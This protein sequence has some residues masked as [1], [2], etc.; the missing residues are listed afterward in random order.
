LGESEVDQLLRECAGQAGGAGLPML[1]ANPDEVT[2]AGDK[3]VKMPGAFAVLYHMEMNVEMDR[4]QYVD[5]NLPFFNH[6]HNDQHHSFL[7][8]KVKTN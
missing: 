6:N 5:Y 8:E 1:V 4:I 2:V 7:L 3:L